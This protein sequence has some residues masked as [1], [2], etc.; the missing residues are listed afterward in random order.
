MLVSL[1]MME[2]QKVTVMLESTAV[3]L[4]GES[5]GFCFKYFFLFSGYQVPVGL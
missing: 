2:M 4:Y 3:F 1:L 5:W